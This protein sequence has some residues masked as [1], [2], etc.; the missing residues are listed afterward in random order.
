MLVIQMS[1]LILLQNYKD[2]LKKPVGIKI[3][4]SSREGIEEFA[5][6]M[7][8]RNENNIPGVPDFISID[9]GDGGSATAP[10]YLMD[11]VGFHVNDAVHI[12]DN[13]LK[14]Y[15]VRD[16]GKNNCSK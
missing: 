2:F 13:V 14:E 1:Y 4:I 3:V 12:A 16:K 9:G 5:K 8:R 7:Q 6:E 11:R 10:L 15:G